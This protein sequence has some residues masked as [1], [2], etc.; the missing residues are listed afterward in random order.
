MRQSFEQSATGASRAT[1]YEDVTARIVR[2][3]EQ[4]TVPWVKPWKESGVPLGLPRNAATQR[5]YTGVNV[6]ILWDAVMRR[7]FARQEWLTYRQA[8]SLGGHIRK[9]ER[10]TVVCHADT[11]VPKAERERA[12]ECGEDPSAVPFLKRFVVFN[13]EQ[14]EGLP[15]HIAAASQSSADTAAGDGWPEVG[16]LIAATGI[17]I[18]EGGNEAYYHPREDF[19]RMPLRTAFVSE[20]DRLCTLLHEVSHATAHPSRLNRD[21]TPRFGS[22]AYGREELIAELASA[23]LC[24]R[25]GIEPQVRHADYLAAWLA[26]LKADSRAIFHAASQ[27][28]KAADYILAGYEPAAIAEA[29]S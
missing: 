17:T 26:I 27:A 1:L 6:L 20:A 25:F 16:A 12:A 9:G 15:T 24:A 14:A 11:F 22:S 5:A 19:I 8:Q 21:L 10:G 2:E 3:L 13:V 28:S 18:R 7:G 23:F 29:V 4:G